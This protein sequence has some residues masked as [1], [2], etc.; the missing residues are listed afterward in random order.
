M[1]TKKITDVVYETTKMFFE[2]NKLES[3]D[4]GFS[5]FSIA[6]YKAGPEARM[7]FHTDYRQE[8]YKIPDV[9]VFSSKEPIYHAVSTVQTG[10]KYIVRTYWHQTHKPNQE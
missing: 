5:S 10:E 6:K 3:D 1:F 8:R 2:E 9:I 7:A 4:I